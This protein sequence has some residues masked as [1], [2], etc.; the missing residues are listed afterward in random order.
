MTET[1]TEKTVVLIEA[2]LKSGREVVLSLEL[3][4]DEV[5]EKDGVVVYRLHP[6]P[7]V[8]EDH[9]IT[10]SEVAYMH[11]SDVDEKLRASQYRTLG[12]EPLVPSS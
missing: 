3:P 12:R 8:V 6:E 5:I 1:T 10:P 11:R 7:G 4:R 9:I 2:L